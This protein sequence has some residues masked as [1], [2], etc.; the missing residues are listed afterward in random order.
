LYIK[1]QRFREKVQ[2]MPLAPDQSVVKTLNDL[3]VESDD[4]KDWLSNVENLIHSID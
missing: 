4:Y 2:L 1:Y 3:Q